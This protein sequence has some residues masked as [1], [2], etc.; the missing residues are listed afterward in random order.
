MSVSVRVSVS[1][2]VVFYAPGGQ[3][4]GRKTP[5]LEQYDQKNAEFGAI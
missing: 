2:S 3:N 1:V 4:I 5:N